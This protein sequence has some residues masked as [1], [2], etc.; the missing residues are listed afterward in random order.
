MTSILTYIITLTIAKMGKLSKKDQELVECVYSMREEVP[1]AFH[2]MFEHHNKQ[3]IKQL[4]SSSSKGGK[5]RVKS[6]NFLYFQTEQG[7]RLGRR[8]FSEDLQPS[9]PQ[10][11]LNDDLWNR[12]RQPYSSR[13]IRVLL[14]YFSFI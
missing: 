11:T 7:D 10:S 1:K 8:P 12:I 5:K 4:V 9:R 3:Y 13:V 2:K 6:C 14:R